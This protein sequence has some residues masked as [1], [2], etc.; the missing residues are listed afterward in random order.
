LSKT[1]SFPA[2]FSAPYE[3]EVLV[4]GGEFIGGNGMI[5]VNSSHTILS[6]YL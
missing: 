1:A 3:A 5:Q 2:G 6:P 4:S